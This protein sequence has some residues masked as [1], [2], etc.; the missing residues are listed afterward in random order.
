MLTKIEML[1]TCCHG[2]AVRYANS[3]DCPADMAKSSFL[4]SASFPAALGSVICPC[5]TVS[6][7]ERL[8]QSRRWAHQ[9]KARVRFGYSVGVGVDFNFVLDVLGN[10]D[11]KC[12]AAA[13]PWSMVRLLW[14]AQEAG[15]MREV[16][17]MGT[18]H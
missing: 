1:V 15:A 8:R 11:R 17:A 13:R 14:R 3:N 18:N 2:A 7:H 5:R 4:L 16:A 6:V 9:A 10:I 12:G